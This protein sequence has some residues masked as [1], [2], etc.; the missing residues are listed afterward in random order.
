MPPSQVS[1]ESPGTSSESAKLCTEEKTDDKTK[2]TTI[3]RK[4]QNRRKRKQ[5]LG[6]TRERDFLGKCVARDSSFDH[7]Q[8]QAP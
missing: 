8:C 2:H 7:R 3:H 6:N 1:R 4:E 5:I